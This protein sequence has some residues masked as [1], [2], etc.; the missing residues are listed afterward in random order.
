MQNLSLYQIAS[1]FP[2]LMEQEEM[3]EEDKRKVEK[4]L[5]ELLQ[6]K[7]QSII[8]YTRNMEL[9]I[10][11]MKIEEKRISDQRKVLENRITKFKEYVKECMETNNLF[12]ITTELGTLN[13]V[14]NP[15]SVEIINEDEISNEYKTQIITTKIDKTKIKD[16][17]KKT[18]EIPAGVNIN[19]Q[20]TSLRIK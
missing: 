20:N 15:P 11:A 13:V 2:M 8:G 17:F 7:S 19:T 4:E 14:K 3:S 10:E 5:T 16:N 6:Q 1:A 18:G 12:K 9:T